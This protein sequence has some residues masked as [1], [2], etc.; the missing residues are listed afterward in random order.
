MYFNSPFLHSRIHEDDRVHHLLKL[1]AESDSLPAEEEVSAVE[2][3]EQ[4]A[5]KT[6]AADEIVEEVPQEAAPEE[7]IAVTE[8]EPQSQSQVEKQQPKNMVFNFLQED[9]LAASQP[10]VSSFLLTVAFRF[11]LTRTDL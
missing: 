10:Q 11:G 7:A 8:P 9:E 4:P 2:E 1:L 6:P 5:E 3:R